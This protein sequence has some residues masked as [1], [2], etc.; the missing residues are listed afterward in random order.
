MAKTDNLVHY[1]SDVADAIR[2]KEGSS[3]PIN[4]QDFSERIRSMSVGSNPGF[5]DYYY[6]ENAPISIDERTEYAWLILHYFDTLLVTSP[7]IIPLRPLVKFPLE[8]DV[9]I[10]DVKEIGS[11]FENVDDIQFAIPKYIYTKQLVLGSG[12]GGDYSF[13]EYVDTIQ[14]LRNMSTYDSFSQINSFLDQLMEH[15]ITS[16][17]FWNE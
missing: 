7:Q 9:F 4:A 15:Q 8:S 14:L 5:A 12:I 16:E 10:L 6:F 2:E 3:D 1:L 17:Q 11:G 13:P